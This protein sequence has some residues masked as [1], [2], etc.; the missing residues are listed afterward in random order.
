MQDSVSVEIAEDPE[1]PT[2]HIEVQKIYIKDISFESPGTPEVFTEQWAPRVSQEMGNTHVQVGESV[3]EAILT[4]TITVNVGDKVAYLAEIKQAGI[5]NIVGHPPEGLERALAIFCP[6][7]L[8]PYA[9]EVISDLSAR[10]GFPSLLMPH[11]NFYRMY[12]DYLKQ[13]EEEQL[14]DSGDSVSH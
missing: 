10:G 12:N 11:I 3:F 5:F 14:T 9:R 7:V 8:F 2:K 4:I 13:N 6:T 1:A